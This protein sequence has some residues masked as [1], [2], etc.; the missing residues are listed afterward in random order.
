MNLVWGRSHW[1]GGPFQEQNQ[2]IQGWNFTG[3]MWQKKGNF[4]WWGSSL[5]NQPV[6]SQEQ[7]MVAHDPSPSCSSKALIAHTS[8]SLGSSSPTQ[9]LKLGICTVPPWIGALC[10]CV[11][12]LPY[13]PFPFP[14][15]LMCSISNSKLAELHTSMS[16]QHNQ[17]QCVPQ[18]SA[19][20]IEL[21]IFFPILFWSLTLSFLPL[22]P[23]Q[24]PEADGW[25]SSSNQAPWLSVVLLNN[26]P[27][28][29]ILHPHH[30]LLNLSPALL[31]RPLTSR[32]DSSLTSL[33]HGPGCCPG[34]LPQTPMIWSQ[35]FY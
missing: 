26:S 1:V 22:P 27:S 3:Q 8:A 20:R 33:L 21:F 2:E 12:Q 7:G 6:S 17:T 28:W 24:L 14:P 19:F 18:L 35:C 25:A 16:T 15:D 11:T 29:G 10:V 4:H 9:H 30:Y 5:K 23:T 34:G 13:T 31:Q 32:P